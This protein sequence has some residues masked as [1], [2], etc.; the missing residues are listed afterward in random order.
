M[1]IKPLHTQFGP[2]L[3]SQQ[4]LYDNYLDLQSGPFKSAINKLDELLA[5]YR[6]GITVR[7][8]Y[9]DILWM[10]DETPGFVNF[11]N[12]DHYNDLLVI[13]GEDSK[14]LQEFLRFSRDHMND[15]SIYTEDYLKALHMIGWGTHK[16]DNKLVLKPDGN[17]IELAKQWGL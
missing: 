11:Q 16:A 15:N 1:Y 3:D 9:I 14:V 5:N 8:N 4:T 2:F 7:V 12:Y 10:D 6:H 17:A 13:H